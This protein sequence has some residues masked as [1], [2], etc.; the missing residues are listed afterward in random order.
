LVSTE[1]DRLLDELIQPGERTT[2]LL[3]AEADK[4]PA[5]EVMDELR[6]LPFLAGRRIVVLKNADKFISTNREL[7]ENYFE[8]PSTTGIL[9]MTVGNLNSRTKLAKKLPK[10]G[11][12]IQ[13]NQPS[14]AQLPGRLKQYALEAHAKTLK[15]EPA[16]LLIELAGEDLSRLYSEVDKLAIYI[17]DRKD[18]TTDDI[19]TLIGHNR[20]YNAFDIIDSVIARDAAKAIDELRRLFNQDRSAE[21]TFV[22]ALAYHLRRMFAAKAMLQ[23]GSSQWDVGKNLRIWHRAD[24]FFKQVKLI[25]LNDIGLLIQRL[26]KTDYEIKTGRVTARAAI[27]ELVMTMASP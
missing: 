10:I 23:K 5:A 9:V 13:V 24:A 7:L 3:N 19:Q 25:S 22:G 16:E 15:S 21:Y 4:I 26:A 17:A 12:L 27:E 11:K 8:N 14:T 18:I 6:T 20:F 2:G 1:C